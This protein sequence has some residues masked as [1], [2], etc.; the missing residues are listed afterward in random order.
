MTRKKDRDGVDRD[1]RSTD[2]HEN[3]RDSAEGVEKKRV[4]E[5]TATG[6]IGNGKMVSDPRFIAQR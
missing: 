4:S 6:L 2:L 5:D 1:E 3:V